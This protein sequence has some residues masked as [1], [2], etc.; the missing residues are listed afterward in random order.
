VATGVNTSTTLANVIQTVLSRARDVIEKGTVMTDKNVV[1]Q[2]TLGDGDGLTYNWPKFGTAL[3]AQSLSEGVP[4]NNPQKLIPTTQQFTTSEAGVQVILTDKA[5]RVTKEAMAARAGRFMGNAMRRKKETDGLGLFSGLARD[6]GTANNPFVPGWI[7]AA[8]VRLRAA[9]ETLQTE[10]AE[11]QITAIIHPFHL[12]DVLTSSG[13]LG[14]NINSTSGYFPIEGWTEEIVREYDIR[15]LYGVIVAT[16]P[17]MSIDASDD[18]IGAIFGNTAFIHVRTSHSMS[19]EKDRD[20]ELR[21]TMM[22]L[23][24]E[25]GDGELED[26]HGFKMTADATAPAA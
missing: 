24:S 22:V 4:I 2:V 12:H 23:T 6:L 14:S 26:Q 17:L 21:A 11:G 5:V 25:Y 18:A 15:Q 7:S 10:P 19:M 1:T 16:A 20:I 8:K 3:S 9:S 13:T